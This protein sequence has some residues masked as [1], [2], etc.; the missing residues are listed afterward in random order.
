MLSTLNRY[1][2]PIVLKAMFVIS[3]ERIHQI[4]AKVISVSGKTPGVR[5]LMARL[6]AVDDGALKN[7]RNIRLFSIVVK[8]V[9]PVAV[10]I[11]LLNGLGVF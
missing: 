7:E 6:F 10:L 8:F 3:P 9:S 4:L 2:Y 5:S 11:V 1:L